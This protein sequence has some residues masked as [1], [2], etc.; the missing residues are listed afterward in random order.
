MHTTYLFLSHPRQDIRQSF[1]AAA[2]WFP[3]YVDHLRPLFRQAF[4]KG[5]QTNVYP[6]QWFLNLPNRPVSS[7]VSTS[8]GG[9][10]DGL[11]QST[12]IAGGLIVAGLDSWR[13]HLG[14][15]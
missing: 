15:S 5:F 4:G 6:C 3:V 10:F 13:P 11:Q 7:S 2:D 8:V 1:I 9:A 14:A 12:Y